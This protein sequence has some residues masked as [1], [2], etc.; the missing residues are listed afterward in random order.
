[1]AYHLLISRRG[2]TNSER[3]LWVQRVGDILYRV[4]WAALYVDL[5]ALIIVMVTGVVARF[6]FNHALSW[7]EELATFLTLFL[8]FVGSAQALRDDQHPAIGL[9]GRRLSPTCKGWLRTSAAAIIG[10]YLIA[11][12]FYGIALVQSSSIEFSTVLKVPMSLPF[13]ALPLG[14]VLAFVQL[15]T[16]EATLEKVG[17][18]D[19]AGNV[20]LLAV[21]SILVFVIIWLG[22]HYIGMDWQLVFWAILPILFAAGVPI[23]FA[24]GTFSMLLISLSQGAPLVIAAGRLVAGVDDPALL[25]IPAFMLAGALLND[26]GMAERLIDFVTSLVGRVRGGLAIA[27]T[28]ASAVFADT[29]GSAVADTAALGSIMIPSM[30]QRGYDDAFA[31]AHQAASGSLGTLFPPSISMIIFGTVTSTSITE[32]FA[33]SILPGLVV[34]LVYIVIAYLFALQRKF[35]RE[36]RRN[37]LQQLTLLWRS[38]FALMAPV[39]VL[40]GILDGVFT[41]TE[42][43]ATASVYVFLIGSIVYRHAKIND[44]ARAAREAIYKTSMVMF[45]IGNTTIF[46]WAL[47]TLGLPQAVATFITGTSSNPEIVLLLIAAVVLLL[48]IFLE[49]PAILIGA[50]PLFMPAIQRL[51]IN[52]VEFGVVTMLATAAGMLLPPIGITLLVSNTIASTQVDQVTRVAVPYVLGCLA[53]LVLVVVFPHLILVLSHI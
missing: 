10:G 25:A 49:P 4:T 20:V 51:G 11:I 29:S 41:P 37:V 50:I 31:A 21:G 7:S 17:P 44:Y 32:L 30:K 33:G 38:L 12:I 24:I 9:F 39:I 43:G 26:T 47:L 28:I 42:A 35:P 48:S 6:V 19:S 8:V 23:G 52:P 16:K 14:A 22:D 40:G 5:V 27:D 53:V 45:I 3:W 15:I 46:S 18:E 2:T 13:T 36:P 34:V 1:M